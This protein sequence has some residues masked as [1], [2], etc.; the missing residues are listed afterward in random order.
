MDEKKK[1]KFSLL[2]F[3]RHCSRV[4][5]YSFKIG[6][7]VNILILLR[8]KRTRDKADLTDSEFAI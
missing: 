1:T 2:N 7:L 4:W 6:I 5:N 8:F 3:N